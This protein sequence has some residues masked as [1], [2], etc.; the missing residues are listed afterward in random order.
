[1]HRNTYYKCHKLKV[2]E[3]NWLIAEMVEELSTNRKGLLTEPMTADITCC[4][5][6]NVNSLVCTP[7]N[8]SQLP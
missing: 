7:L 3:L 6:T 8:A 2:T 4:S 1:M 5:L